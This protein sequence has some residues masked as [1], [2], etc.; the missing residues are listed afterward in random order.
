MKTAHIVL[1]TAIV[2][3]AALYAAY[4]AQLWSVQRRMMF[5]GA[6]M[7]AVVDK[8]DWPAEAVQLKLGD[9]QAVLAIWLP[10]ITEAPASTI[11]FFHGNAEFAYQSVAAISRLSGGS[12]NLLSLEYPGYAG[13]PGEPTLVSIRDASLIAY[14]WLLQ[15]PD[16][17]PRRII[18]L[19][20]SVGGG[21]AAELSRH[22]PLAALVLVSTFTSI[23]DMARGLYVPST[24]IRDPFDNRAAVAAFAG[25]VLILHGRRDD[26]LPYAF[27]VALGKASPRAEFV[28]LSCAH[29][30]CA[31]DGTELSAALAAFLEKH[32]L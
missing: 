31:L 30:D 7:R 23:A 32:R 20:R 11:V 24:L 28:T 2:F 21:P 10:A 14:D 29:N 26:V 25:P 5:P 4:C 13:A 3:A 12:R 6:Q 27:G 15:Q 16:V 8:R 1:L 22:R 19:G 18:A 17:D 9:A